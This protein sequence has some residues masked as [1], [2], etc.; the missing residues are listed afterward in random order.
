MLKSA[1]SAH[2][3]DVLNALKTAGVNPEWVQVGNETNDGLLWPE[4]KASTNMAN[5]A[6]LVTS[7]YDAVKSVFL[8]AKVIIHLTNA[9]LFFTVEYAKT[10][11]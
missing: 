3:T 4:G 8:S 2:T 11:S 1:L 9:L 7:G 5:Y 6:Q 10:P